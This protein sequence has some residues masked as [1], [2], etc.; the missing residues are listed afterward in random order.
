MG[1]V[2]LCHVAGNT[3]LSY[4]AGELMMLSSSKARFR[5]EL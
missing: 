4:K 1:Q 3:V 2:H 5:E